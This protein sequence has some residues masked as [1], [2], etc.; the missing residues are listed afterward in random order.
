MADTKTFYTLGTGE[1]VEALQLELGNL[2][3]A[4]TWCGGT[5]VHQDGIAGV[6]FIGQETIEL[7]K[8]GDFLLKTR[9][10]DFHSY[11]A[12]I[13]TSVYFEYKD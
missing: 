9:L 2:Q 7:A 5:V 12:R 10:N 8:V 3:A 11:P 13:F 1:P 6:N 4:A